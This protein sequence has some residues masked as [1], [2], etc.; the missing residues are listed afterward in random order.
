MKGATPK[1]RAGAGGSAGFRVFR[2][3][4]SKRTREAL[5]RLYKD[6]TSGR[7]RNKMLH[8]YLEEWR[9]AY[10]E[11]KLMREEAGRRTPPRPPPLFLLVKFIIPEN[12]EKRG[13][14]DAPCV[15]D[16]KRGELR[17]PSYNIKIP[18]RRSLL[19]ALIEENELEAR[20]DFVLQ[21][22]HSGKLR[23]IAHRAPL[24]PQ[25]S[26]PLRVIAVDENS[27]HGFALAAF[28]FD[29][30]GCKLAYFEK[31]RPENHGCR[32]QL[33]AILQS[34]ADAPSGERRQQL[35]QLLP[36]E[37]AK[38]LAPERAREMAW[39]A[40][41]KEK[42]LNNNFVQRITTRVRELVR[43]ARRRGA[44]VVIL[45][46][47]ID[48]KSLRGT[49][50]QGTLLRARRALENLARYEGA[51]LIELRASGKR[52]PLCSSEGTE[53]RRTMRVRVYMCRRC[54]AV[55]DRDKAATLNL[56]AAYFEKLRGRGNE[57]ALAERALA[58]LKQWLKAHSRALQR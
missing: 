51:S 40:R 29:D 53:V 12:G 49:G 4:T 16:L 9:K 28:D 56:A 3:C 24:L 55:W 33:A 54:G 17:I 41:R 57:A 2:V 34:F 7:G 1:E 21:V 15:I 26:T 43:E 5:V 48:H 52:C 46:D 22:T 32:R 38:A 23:I 39:Q 44:A 27:R 58:S 36:E 30:R 42:R 18:L 19:R 20:P 8:Y 25:L 47:P 45:V 37:L 31:L 14:H 6:A 11:V 10:E 50:L 35:G 13:K